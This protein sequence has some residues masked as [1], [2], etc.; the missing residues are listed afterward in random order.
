LTDTHF[1][2]TDVRLTWS[3]DELIPYRDL[4]EAG[5]VDTIMVGHLANNSRWGGVATQR[6]ATAISQLL[7][8]DLKF[9]GVV[10]SDDLTMRAVAQGKSSLAEVVRSSVSGGVDLLLIGQPGDPKIENAGAYVNSAVIDGIAS[11]DIASNT[12]RESLQRVRSL[13]FKLQAM[14]MQFSSH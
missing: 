8:S 14:Q 6:G 3:A 2:P 4:I 9:D 10:V 5:V 1:L 13:K 11:G 12:I 7:R